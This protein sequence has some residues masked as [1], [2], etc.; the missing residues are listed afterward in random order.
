M[1]V[2][3]FK[4]LF[5]SRACLLLLHS[6]PITSLG[7]SSTLLQQYTLAQSCLPLN[8]SR[9]TIHAFVASRRSTSTQPQGLL[10]RCLRIT[11]HTIPCTVSPMLACTRRVVATCRRRALPHAAVWAS[12]AADWLHRE[13]RVCRR[14]CLPALPSPPEPPSGRD[15][16]AAAA[17]S[18]PV[19]HR[20]EHAARA[21][22]DKDGSCPTRVAR[23]AAV[24]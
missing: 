11:G 1:S 19:V 7:D 10:V 20:G 16:A 21:S 4:C 23:G 18:A 3:T 24:V 5:G 9:C 2:P 8:V 17:V 15:Q 22:G 14:V 12:V 6:T 13:R